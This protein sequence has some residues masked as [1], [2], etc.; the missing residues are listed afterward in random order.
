[1][2]REE[3]VNEDIAVRRTSICEGVEVGSCRVLSV[4]VST[5][6]LTAHGSHSGGVSGGTDNYFEVRFPRTLFRERV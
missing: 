6:R 1:M 5:C 4:V 3:R 2:Q